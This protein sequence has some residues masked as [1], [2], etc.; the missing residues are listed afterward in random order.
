MYLSRTLTGASFPD[1][2][3]RIGGKDHSTVIY[4]FRKIQK[5]S[6]NDPKTEKII[7]DIQEILKGRP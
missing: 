7:T 5:M 4:A 1:I 2:G 6:E 3:N